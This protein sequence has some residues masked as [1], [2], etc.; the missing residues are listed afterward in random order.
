MNLVGGLT[1]AGTPFNPTNYALASHTHDYVPTS[2]TVNAKALSS[3]ITLTAADVG[4][5]T[6]SH[7]HGTYDRAS[8]VLSGA[9]VFSNIV[10]TD[11]IVT[12]LA[13]RALTAADVG[14]AASSHTHD[15]VPTGRTVNGKALTANISLTASDVGAAASSHTHPYQQ[16]SNVAHGLTGTI[17]NATWTAV[18]YGKTFGV[19]PTVVATGV[20]NVAGDSFAKVRNRSTTGFEII[21]GGTGTSNAFNWIAIVAG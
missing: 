3:N 7:T 14:A 2:R 13:T 12:S 6:S 9:N 10:V 16:L 1:I 15:Y 11:G 4:A 19:I 17:T 5:A 21:V 18:S 20:N 8:S